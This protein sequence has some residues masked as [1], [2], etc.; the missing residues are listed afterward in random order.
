[1]AEIGCDQKFANHNFLSAGTAGAH[2]LNP[3]AT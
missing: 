3:L 1:M 2:P